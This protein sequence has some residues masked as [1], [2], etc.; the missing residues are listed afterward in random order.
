[1]K[2]PDFKTLPAINNLK[3]KMGIPRNVYGDLRVELAHGELTLSELTKVTSASGLDVSIDEIVVLSDGPLGYKGQRVVVY[4]RDKS[5]YAIGFSDPRFHVGNCITLTQMRHNNR[6]GR[7][8]A[9]NDSSGRFE[10]NIVSHGRVRTTSRD[11]R[12]CQNCLEY[13]KVGNFSLSDSRSKRETAVVSFSLS[14][15]FAKYGKTFHIEVPKYDAQTAPIN[16]YSSGFSETSKAFRAQSSWR[17]QEPSCGVE[18]SEATLRK[19][20]HTHHV[21]GEKYDNSPNNLRVL[22]IYCHA[23]T[24]CISI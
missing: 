11:L 4:I 17:C 3:D 1:M 13:M 22:C 6:F 20:L 12:V 16:S 5:D 23:N 14:E 7:Y 2:L 24:Q 15:F 19:Y 18:L 21:N 10:V 9:T 8:V